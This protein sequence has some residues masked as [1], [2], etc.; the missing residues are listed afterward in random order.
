VVFFA[1]SIFAEGPARLFIVTDVEAV[2]TPQEIV[3][4]YVPSVK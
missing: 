4:V 2:Q 3:T 1:L